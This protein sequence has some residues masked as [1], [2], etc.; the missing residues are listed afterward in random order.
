MIKKPITANHGRP[1]K[2]NRI[3]ISLI[4]KERKKRNLHPV[5]FDK[6]L[7]LH[8]RRWSGHMAHRRTL[9]HSNII[10]ENCAMV[11]SNGSP[12]SIARSCFRV[13]M[14]SDPHRAWML[15]E[16]NAGIGGTVIIHY[17]GFAYRINGKYAYAALAFK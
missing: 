17:V 9:M 1:D 11:P 10:P 4:N 7:R 5:I 3:I 14:K 16:Y 12:A 15:Q 13:W 8:A 6:N 2:I